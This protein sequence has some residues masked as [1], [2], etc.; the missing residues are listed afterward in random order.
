MGG[1][2]PETSRTTVVKRAHKV[3]GEGMVMNK[4]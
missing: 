1:A 4:R 2:E 3:E